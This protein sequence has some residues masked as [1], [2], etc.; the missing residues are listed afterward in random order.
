MAKVGRLWHHTDLG[1]NSNSA[2]YWL[3][4]WAGT[5]TSG[6]LFSPLGNGGQ[7]YGCP[8]DLCGHTGKV[9]VAWFIITTQYMKGAF[10]SYP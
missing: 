10:G 3:I 5:V 9:H 1:S 4:L 7:L 6:L 8:M 2:T